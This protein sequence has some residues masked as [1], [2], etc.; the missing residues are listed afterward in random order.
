MGGLRRALFV[1]RREM[2]DEEYATEPGTI[3]MYRVNE[4]YNIIVVS[5]VSKRLTCMGGLAS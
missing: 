4:Q 1:L 3:R 5:K 2:G